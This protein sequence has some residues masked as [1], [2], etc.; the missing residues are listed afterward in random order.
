METIHPND[1]KNLDTDLISSVTMKNGTMIFIDSS[2]PEKTKKET[3]KNS[4]KPSL[5]GI[6]A[7]KP[8]QKTI[9]LEINSPSTLFFKGKIDKNK[10]KSDF[11]LGTQIINNMSF[12]YK[13]LK[14][15][16]ITNII[17]KEN[18]SNNIN[19]QDNK[20]N[21]DNNG[22][23]NEK[24]KLKEEKNNDKDNE[25]LYS[26][27]PSMK[28]CEDKEVKKIESNN[29]NN[30]KNLIFNKMEKLDLNQNN[31]NNTNLSIPIMNLPKNSQNNDNNSQLIF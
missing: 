27:K 14:S 12:S 4:N 22:L 13:G 2:A 29:N 17:E 5:L 7:I 11:R 24:E 28:I 3:N 25:S 1:F 19:N 31:E 6:N 20:E 18:N 9:K 10:Y 21:F 23:I 30:E 26:N 8:S 15:K 16:N